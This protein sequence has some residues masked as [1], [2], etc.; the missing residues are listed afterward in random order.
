VAP[1]RKCTVCPKRA[2]ELRACN[3]THDAICVCERGDYFSALTY[4]CKTCNPC[5]HG[6]GVSRTCTRNRDT[7]C[8]KCP[9][10]TFSAI[11]SGTMGC[12]M[13]TKCRTD[14]ILLQECSPI[15][16][17]VCLRDIHLSQKNHFPTPSNKDHPRNGD[18]SEG[19]G[20][21]VPLAFILFGLIIFGLIG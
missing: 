1:C 12:E 13:C 19:G 7:V 15:Q 17:T 10:E 18:Y 3:K 20:W 9:P 8:R 11:I 16:D 6:F 21:L 14:Q 4:E 2:I 5:P